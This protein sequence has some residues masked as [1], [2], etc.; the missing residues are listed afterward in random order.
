MIRLLPI[1]RCSARLLAALAVLALVLPPALSRAA[2]ASAP[3]M[4]VVCTADG[5]VPVPVDGDK[6]HADH[7]DCP[8][9][10]RHDLAALP[11]PPPPLPLARGGALG[12]EVALPESVRQ[13]E[14][15]HRRPP[16]RAPPALS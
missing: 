6:G 8:A 4:L 3:L 1:L 14:G 12:F 13:G 5:L 16:A 11:P 7:A 2:A 9:C 10:L 15:P